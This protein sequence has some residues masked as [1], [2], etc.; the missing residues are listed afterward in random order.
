MA[1][2]MTDESPYLDGPGPAEIAE[3]WIVAEH[4]RLGHGGSVA[5][6]DVSF[7]I[8][9]GTS[10]ALIGPNGSGK[11]TLL[12]GVAGLL[13]PLAGGLERAPAA[14]PVGYVLQHR[15]EHAW[16][17]LTVREVLRMGCYGRRRLLGRLRADDRTVIAEAAERLEV[18]AVLDRQFG[19]L[20]GGQRQRVLMAQALVQRPRLLLLDEPIT[21]LDLASQDR[22]LRVVEEETAAGSTVLLSTHHLEE[23][24]RCDRVMLLGGGGIVADG[25]PDEVLTPEHMATAFIGRALAVDAESGTGLLVLDEHGHDDP[26]HEPDH[27]G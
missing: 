5:L 24:R 14:A 20:S 10:V 1:G 19:A 25:A 21:G 18:T 16:M 7:S 11:T 12:D 6:D 2:D 23:A 13:P 27:R 26:D 3:P 4:L 8:G 15:S 22:I 9:P 17:P